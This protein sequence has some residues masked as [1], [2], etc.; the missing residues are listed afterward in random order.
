MST[1]LMKVLA[2]DDDAD[3]LVYMSTFLE[4]NGYD[5]RTA[6]DSRAALAALEDYD[7]D[8]IILD[9]MMPGRS[10]L[11]LLVKL[12]KDQRWCD[13]KLIMLTG[14]DKVSH[15]GGRNY[16]SGHSGIRGADAVLS[17]PLDKQ[18]LLDALEG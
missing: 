9:V 15:N 8:V 6:D 11:D 18:A 13:K 16:L 4:D 17:K 7:P 10:G 12:R 14:N 5:V 1:E 3:I 2:V